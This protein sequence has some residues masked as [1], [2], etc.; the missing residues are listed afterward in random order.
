[1]SGKTT[2]P[3]L[4]WAVKSYYDLQKVRLAVQNRRPKKGAPPIDL[5]PD[6]L[7]LLKSIKTQM[8]N[9]EKE[10]ATHIAST[11]GR[12]PMFPWLENIR[13]IGPILAAVLLVQFD[14]YKARHASSFWR[15]CGLDV[16]DGAA[17]KPVKGKKLSYNKWLKA[18]MLT[19]GVGVGIL[20]SCLRKT[21]PEDGTPP[22]KGWVRW[23]VIPTFSPV[24]KKKAKKLEDEG[25][26]ISVEEI[27]KKNGTTTAYYLV[28]K[29]AYW[30]PP[31]EQGKY[32]KIYLDR[33]HRRESSKWGNSH[34]HRHQDAMRVMVKIFLAD[35]W[36]AWRTHEGLEVSEPYAVAKLGMKPHGQ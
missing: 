2:Y 34:A 32:A 8:Q 9:L 22:Y 19:G 18:K 30:L 12:H 14:P 27:K 13:G 21:D 16:V 26:T 17:P 4:R 23:G 24:T 36:A 11:V 31:G 1:M 5:G 29:Y 10:A 7:V 28:E 25:A 20:K 15:Y 33:K 6:D 35:F 3:T